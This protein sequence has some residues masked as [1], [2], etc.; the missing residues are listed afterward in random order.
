MWPACRLQARIVRALT[1]H[2]VGVVGT[3]PLRLLSSEQWRPPI[4]EDEWNALTGV[5]ASWFG[6][7]DEMSLYRPPQS[8]RTGFAGL[9]LKEGRGVGFVKSRPGWD[10]G[11]EAKLIETASRA[12]SF[13][14]PSLVGVSTGPE[15]S[16]MGLTALQRGLHSARLPTPPNAVAE[17]ISGLLDQFIPPEPEHGHWMVMHGDMGPWNL[18]YLDD[19]G[20]ILFDWELSRRAPPGA[21]ILFHTV[22]S[23]AMRLGGA[24]ELRGLEEAARF[25]KAEIPRRFAD[26][27]D[28]QRLASEM[29][30]GL[31]RLS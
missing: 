2:L 10:F 18:R 9:L 27:T 13:T 5:W 29:L 28:D 8:D 11:P 12:R 19:I 24:S 30:A 4:D 1:Y 20:F 22:A 23:R 14:T 6:S 7:F 21:D 17:E 31:R 3:L 25:W 16:T 15:W 26:T